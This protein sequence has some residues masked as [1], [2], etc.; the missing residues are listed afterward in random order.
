MLNLSNW[1]I[2][3]ATG[4]LFI[5]LWQ[6]IPLPVKL[7]QYRAIEKFHQCDL[8]SG[9]WIYSVLSLC[10]E[11]SLW[12]VFGF[13]YIPIVSEGLTGGILSFIMWIFVA[14]WKEKF[15]NILVI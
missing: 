5:Y 13:R 12:T 8:C 14:G 9:V 10:T 3:L 2:L 1:I 7:E 4:R 6:Q 11:L 15:S